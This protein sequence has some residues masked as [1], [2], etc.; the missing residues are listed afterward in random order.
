MIRG[1]CRAIASVSGLLLRVRVRASGLLR[2]VRELESVLGLDLLAGVYMHNHN[3][4]CITATV[5]VG[6]RVTGS[7]RSS[8]VGATIDVAVA[9]AVDLG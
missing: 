3:P 8:G 7:Y 1:S 4:Y 5:S 2:R 9:V 6:F